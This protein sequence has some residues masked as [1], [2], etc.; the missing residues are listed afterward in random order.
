MAWIRRIPAKRWAAAVCT[1][2]GRV[3]WAF[4]LKSQAVDWA[5][6]H[7]GGTNRQIEGDLAELDERR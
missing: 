3:T 4:P 2:G 6:E 1:T 5:T 7:E